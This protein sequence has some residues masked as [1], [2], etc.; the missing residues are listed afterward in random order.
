MEDFLRQM[1][2]MAPGLGQAAMGNGPQFS[3]FM[4]GFER[5]R[6]ADEQRKRIAQQDQ[7]ASEDRQR[8]MTRQNT[9]DQFAKEDQAWQ[10]QQR[11]I[12]LGQLL[13][14]SGAQAE[15]LPEAE[16]AIDST[17]GM[18]TPEQQGQLGPTRDQAMRAAVGKVTSRQ[19]AELKRWVEQLIN[20]EWVV[21]QEGSDPDVT[22]AMPAR[23]RQL[24]ES[25][26]GKTA[27]RKSDVLAMTETLEPA[28]RPSQEVSLQAKDVMVGG[29]P[30]MA[31]YNPKTGAYTDQAGNPITVDPI[32]PQSSGGGGGAYPP[33][34]QR[35]IDAVIKGF[36]SQPV[37]RRTQVMSEGVNFAQALND[38]TTNPADD[39]ALIY[40]FAKVM[41]PDSVVREGE[42]ATVQKYAQ[43]WAER[44]KFDV[45]RIFSNS[46]FLTPEAR[47]NMK[48]TLMTKFGVERRAYDNLRNEYGKRIDRIT[49]KTGG[50]E[51]LTDY[52]AA[53]PQNQGGGGEEMIEAIDP[54]GKRHRAPKGTPL[55]QGWKLAGG[56]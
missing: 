15:T 54:N 17:F 38:N 10:Q 48:A 36:D 50:V 52:G 31:N 45:T 8:Q 26:T 43:S 29:K 40:A 9:A 4:Q 22:Q 46:Q 33:N 18:L 2:G 1:I 7:I 35:R 16:G 30:V 37:V 11:L 21:Q 42:Y 14:Q 24:A 28:R 49:G 3:A 39:Q 51:E 5:A 6:Q 44:F 13:N 56:A 53:F 47:R 34:V 23:I 32:L 41:D 12:S 19:K 20:S 25:M 55:P 27:F